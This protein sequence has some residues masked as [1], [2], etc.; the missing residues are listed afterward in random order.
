M[1]RATFDRRCG[2]CVEAKAKQ[3]MD[4]H[5]KSTPDERARMGHSHHDSAA[6]QKPPPPKL[7]VSQTRQAI[8]DVLAEVK[9]PENMKKINALKH[10]VDANP[11]NAMMALMQLMPM[12]TE[13]LGDIMKKYGFDGEGSGNVM[14]FFNALQGSEDEEVQR[15]AKELRQIVVPASMQPMVESMFAGNG[16]RD[17]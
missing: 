1:T 9:K 3:A 13:M 15:K 5:R 2:P 7:S 8:A 4:A 10:Q 12:A 16:Q 17:L 6:A 14:Q 11:D